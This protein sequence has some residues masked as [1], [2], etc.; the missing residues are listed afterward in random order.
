MRAR[1]EATV[2]YIRY[3]RGILRKAFARPK[4]AHDFAEQ[5]KCQRV[6]IVRELVGLRRGHTSW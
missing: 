6:E 1:T 5:F 3:P 2:V 4:E